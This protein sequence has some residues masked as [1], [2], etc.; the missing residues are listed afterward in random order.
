MQ[1]LTIHLISDSSGQTV[2]SVIKTALSQFDNL[3]AK[4][5]LW[6]MIR[7]ENLLNNVINQIEKNPGVVIYTMADHDLREKLKI[8]CR[9]K[10][11]PCIGAVGKIIKQLEQFTKVNTLEEN[12]YKIDN[13]YF[14]RVEAID[15]AIQHDDGQLHNIEEADILILGPSRTSKSPTCIYLA[16][17]GYKAANIPLI[18]DYPL[19]ELIKKAIK[20]LIVGFTINPERLIEIRKNRLLSIAEKNETD[21]IKIDKIREEV[22]AVKKLCVQNNWPLIDVTRKSIEETSAKIIQMLQDKKRQEYKKI[23]S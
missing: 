7:D 3:K 12:F 15:F 13:D 4:K 16:Y 20:P 9:E 11:L 1:K 17:S 23:I 10:K 21:Y 5:F 19:P 2:S 22:K 6:T 18:L 8:Y 14:E